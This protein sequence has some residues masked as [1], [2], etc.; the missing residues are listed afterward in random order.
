LT[1]IRLETLIAAPPQRCFD[2]SLSVDLHLASAGTTRE[3]VVSGPAS[4]V[5]GPGD[6]VT[7][8]GWHMGGRRRLT[9]R[10]TAYDPPRMFR[11]EMVEGPFR[12]MRHD[13]LFEPHDRGTWMRDEF[14]FASRFPLFDV[15]V[16]RPYLRRFL[17]R[18][19]ATI[20]RVAESGEWRRYL[21]QNV[22]PRHGRT[23]PP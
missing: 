1:L 21:E 3:R 8:A 11:D 10:V 4:G 2:L 9:V 20:R 19:N 5:L 6:T 16:L 15:L 18:R 17:A 12:H 7:W 13:H 14:D 22:D 23:I